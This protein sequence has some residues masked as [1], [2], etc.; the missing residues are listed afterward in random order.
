M[1]NSLW[2]QLKTR[3]VNCSKFFKSWFLEKYEPTGT[4]TQKGL[5]SLLCCLPATGGNSWRQNRQFRKVVSKTDF[6]AWKFNF[7]ITITDFWNRAKAYGVITGQ[8]GQKY[9]VN[10][11][12]HQHSTLWS[13]FCVA[14]ITTYKLSFGCQNQIEAIYRRVCHFLKIKKKC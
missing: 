5:G 7:S 12:G 11:V 13:D 4:T 10:K 14:K 9:F 3:K 8:D 1:K 6:F 2:K